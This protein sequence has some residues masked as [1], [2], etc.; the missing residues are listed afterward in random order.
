MR[1][2]IQMF[3]TS[4]YRWY[5]KNTTYICK[6]ES[7]QFMSEYRLTVRGMP[8]TL[9]DM[10]K[11][12]NID[13]NYLNEFNTLIESSKITVNEINSFYNSSDKTLLTLNKKFEF[14]T[15]SKKAELKKL[16]CNQLKNLLVDNG[17]SS[18]TGTKNC[19]N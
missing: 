14:N 12:L 6:E 19:F 3:F 4:I 2:E 9:K 1:K 8:K 15:E 5:F 18:K 13:S 16:K 11:K 10:L 7:I 17:L